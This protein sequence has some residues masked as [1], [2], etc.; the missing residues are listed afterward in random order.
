MGSQ[1][2]RDNWATFTFH[3]QSSGHSVWKWM[4]MLLLEMDRPDF[5]IY[6]DGPQ[7]PALSGCKTAAPGR[8][9]GDLLEVEEGTRSASQLMDQTGFLSRLMHHTSLLFLTQ[10]SGS[11]Q[12]LYTDGH[13][14]VWQMAVSAWRRM[15]AI[16]FLFKPSTSAATRHVLEQ[17]AT[18]GARQNTGRKWGGLGMGAPG[19][20][21]GSCKPFPQP[22]A[23]K[24]PDS[25]MFLLTAL[26][27]SA[28]GSLG[29][30]PVQYRCGNESPVPS[31][32]QDTGASWTFSFVTLIC[33]KTGVCWQH[34]H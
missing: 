26:S 33:F 23:G 18:P 32:L 6:L 22:L 17:R 19:V 11:P 12:I 9:C 5:C 34:P 21:R 27:S 3:S 10:S 8:L 20:P 30:G 28:A 25:L 4:E 31:P 16:W 13:F 29:P 24:R 2:V 15:R 14:W 1:K 7:W